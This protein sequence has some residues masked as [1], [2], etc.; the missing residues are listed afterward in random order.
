MNRY[1]GP[2]ALLIM[3]LSVIAGAQENSHAVAGRPLAAVE[4]AYCG[5]RPGKPPL[6]FL[7][8]NI[9]VRNLNDKPEWVLFPRALYEKAGEPAKQP[10]VDGVEIFS[11]LPER[12]VI[13]AQFLGSVRL[14]PESAGGFQALLLPAGASISIR[15]F[16]I[17]F[18]GDNFSPLPLHV[19]IANQVNL[20]KTPADRW[21][22]VNLLSAKSANVNTRQ[23]T[24]VRSRFTPRRNEIPVTI[25]KAGEITIPDALA[26]S[27]TEKNHP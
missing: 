18:W 7:S 23:I 12:N 22:R 17:E 14:Q 16:A 27:C 9:T 19:V 2:F 10:G 5:M 6:K 15:D 3:M 26:K 1:F 4:T 25:D 8:F 24:M 11:K 13:V 20:G 21:A